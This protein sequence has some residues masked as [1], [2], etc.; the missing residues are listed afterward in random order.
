VF[1]KAGEIHATLLGRG[2]VRSLPAIELRLAFGDRPAKSGSSFFVG[3][4]APKGVADDFRRVAIKAGA[5]FPFDVALHFRRE[6]AGCARRRN[7]AARTET[8]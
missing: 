8:V 7:E 6:V 3:L 1:G 5:D 2:V 4:H